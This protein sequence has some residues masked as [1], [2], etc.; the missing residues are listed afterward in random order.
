MGLK[1]GYFAK[2]PYFEG[3]KP[4]ENLIRGNKQ[5]FDKYAFE[6]VVPFFYH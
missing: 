2:K 6:T 5:A 3:S 1:F 4:K